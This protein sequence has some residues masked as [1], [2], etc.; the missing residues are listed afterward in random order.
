MVTPPLPSSAAV[1]LRMQ[2]QRRSSTDPELALRRLLHAAGYR[3]RVDFK[4]PGMR[5]RTIDIAFTRRRVAVFVDGCFWHSCPEHATQ[6]RSNADWWRQKL[7]T[8]VARDRETD[9]LLT[10]MGWSVVRVWE[11]EAVE[12]A[13][14]RVVRALEGR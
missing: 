12:V 3:Y 13:L 9:A 14:A 4:V 11:H 2:R 5:R 6:P 1:S 10:A 8:N 7:A